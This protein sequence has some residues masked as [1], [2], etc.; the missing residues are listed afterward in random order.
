MFRCYCDV[1]ITIMTSFFVS[2]SYKMS[3]VPDLVEQA[4]NLEKEA[5]S[6]VWNKNGWTYLKTLNDVEVYWKPSTCF[7]GSIY[8]FTVEVDQLC[9][10]VYDV[11]K[12]PDV[13]DDRLSWDK[14]IK[15]Y[16]VVEKDIKVGLI[17]TPAV[18]MGMI[19]KREFVDL[20]YFRT[21][22]CDVTDAEYSKTCWI[23]ATSIDHPK[24]SPTKGYVRAKNYPAGYSVSKSKRYP[25]KSYMELYVNCDIGGMLPRTLVEA[26]LPSQQ[27]A[28]IRSVLEEVQRRKT[29]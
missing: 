4:K 23:F 7:N 9:D 5:L 28:Y 16:E 24:H 10:D 21:Y 25:N 2:L 19:S 20:Y 13:T 11:M 26:A 12:P 14:S 3:I 1:T 27:I 22:D 8:K 17:T 15:H 18:A 29:K 6:V